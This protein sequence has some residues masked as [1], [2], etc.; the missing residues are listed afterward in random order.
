M[1]MPM[2]KIILSTVAATVISFMVVSVLPHSASAVSKPT[3]TTITLT[4]GAYKTTINGKKLTLKP[5]PGYSGLVWAK[6]V[7]FG[8]NLGYA[9]LFVPQA[10]GTPSVLKY[11]NTNIGQMRSLTP[12]Y[13]DHTLGYNVDVVV[14]PKTKKVYIV[15]GTKSVGASARIT[16]IGRKGNTWVNNPTVASTENKGVVLVKFLKL[17]TNEYGLVTMISG[18]SSTLKVWKYSSSTHRFDE[19]TSYDKSL[20][21]ISGDTLTL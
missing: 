21:S 14:Q 8:K 4:K 20:I 12:F 13:G 18:N 17:Y 9:F 1:N 15:F 11:Y 16:E 6:K 2:R 5:F 10:S 19:D 3:I 7:N